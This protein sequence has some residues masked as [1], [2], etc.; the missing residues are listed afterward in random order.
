MRVVYVCARF[1]N[2][3]VEGTG[4]LVGRGGF[5]VKLSCESSIL[6]VRPTTEWRELLLLYFFGLGSQPVFR[7]F[8]VWVYKW[9][10]VHVAIPV[11]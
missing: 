11:E 1:M 6:F 5:P 3:H 8:P 2:G 10:G 9:S 7:K 4:S